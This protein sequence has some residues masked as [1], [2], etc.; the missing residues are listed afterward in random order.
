MSRQRILGA[1]ILG[2]VLIALS[3]L[4]ELADWGTEGFGVVQIAAVI[5]GLLL[6]G[7]GLRYLRA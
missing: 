1:I 5:I 6:V 4:F 2:I 7:G 3:I